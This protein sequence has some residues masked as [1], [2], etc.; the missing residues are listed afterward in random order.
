MRARLAIASSDTKCEIREVVLRDK[1]AEFIAASQKA[2]V[3]VLVDIDGAVL[4]ESL[5]IISWALR[6]ND[7]ERLF[8]EDERAHEAMQ[9]VIERLDG[10]FKQSLDRYKYTNRHAGADAVAEREKASEFLKDLDKQL[11]GSSWLFGDEPSYADF[12]VLPFVRQ[13]AFVDRP[14]F[15]AQPW[16]DLRVWLDRFIDSQRF[17]AIMVKYPKWL[18]GDDPTFFPPGQ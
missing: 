16:P 6:G 2:T 13:F 8:P 1:P 12:A 5:D 9:A 11:V 15:D 18:S 4:E 10:S 3:P 14:W 17:H 7:P